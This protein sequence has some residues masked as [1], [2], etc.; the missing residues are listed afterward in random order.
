[1]S[2]LVFAD[3]ILVFCK[4]NSQSLKALEGVFVK[5]AAILG[6][7]VRKEKSNLFLSK[8]CRMW[9]QLFQLMGINEGTLPISL[10]GQIF[11]KIEHIFFQCVYNAYIYKRC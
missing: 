7:V 6:L 4:E 3:D 8:S 10:F 9:A 11:G 1:M 2:H 5:F